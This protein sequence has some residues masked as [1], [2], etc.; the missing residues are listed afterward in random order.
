M[1][2]FIHSSTIKHSFFILSYVYSV[3]QSINQLVSQSVSQS[4][5]QLANHPNIHSVRLLFSHSKRNVSLHV[6]RYLFFTSLYVY[7][8]FCM[9]GKDHSAENVLVFEKVLIH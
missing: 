9:L 6:F 4:A 5:T 3:S 8:L 1:H 7:M 2:R